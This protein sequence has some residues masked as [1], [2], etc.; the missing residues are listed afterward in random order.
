MVREV[1]GGISLSTGQ[2]GVSVSR[3]MRWFDGVDESAGWLGLDCNRAGQMRGASSRSCSND[4][5]EPGK[6][7]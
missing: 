7:Q 4:F 2:L 5:G 3:M 1:F 6:A